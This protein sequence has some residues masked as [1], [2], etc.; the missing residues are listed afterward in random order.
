MKERNSSSGGVDV[1]VGV[2]V[3]DELHDVSRSYIHLATLVQYAYSY[4]TY[5]W[6]G[7]AKRTGQDR[8]GQ[9]KIGHRRIGQDRTGHRKIGHR[10][11]EHR[12][13][14]QHRTGH[15]KI[16]HRK[17]G[18]RRIEQDRTGQRK[19]GQDIAR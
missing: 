6:I 13:I 12:R 7:Q 17:I 5:T 10:R 8:T 2:I 11:I 14:G 19:T 4:H 16:G 18:H 1:G 15:R 3:V 9:R